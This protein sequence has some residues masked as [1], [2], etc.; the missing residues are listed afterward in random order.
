[1]VLVCYVIF[2][3]HVTKESCDLIARSH[4]GKLHPVKF[5]GHRYSGRDMFLVCHVILM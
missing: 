3:N 4:Q 5:G 1:M 2:Q